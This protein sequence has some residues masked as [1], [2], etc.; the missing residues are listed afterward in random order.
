MFTEFESMIKKQAGK[1]S[2]KIKN[3]AAPALDLLR[4]NFGSKSKKVSVELPADNVSILI[5]RILPPLLRNSIL[6]GGR[7]RR[8]NCWLR[9]HLGLFGGRRILP[10]RRSLRSSGLSP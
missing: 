1:L 3:T 2:N 8:R 4:S 5:A 9:V 10:P 6:V 7:S